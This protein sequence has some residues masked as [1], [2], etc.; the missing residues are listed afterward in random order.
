[1][2]NGEFPTL[3]WLKKRP[4][5]WARV[6][7]FVLANPVLVQGDAQELLAVLR[8]EAETSGMSTTSQESPAEPARVVILAIEGDADGRRSSFMKAARMLRELGKAVREDAVR[9]V[10]VQSERA[11]IAPPRLQ[12]LLSSEILFQV[13]AAL[14]GQLP[15]R[16][17]RSFR[18]SLSLTALD[19]AGL[20]I[21]RFG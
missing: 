6:A 20:R 9:I 21:L 4:N 16:G 12:K 8:V 10:V 15:R 2:H 5:R 13:A 1:V 14:P 18:E 3:P 17:W 11:R 19:A 7:D